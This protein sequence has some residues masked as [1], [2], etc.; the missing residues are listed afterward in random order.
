MSTNLQFIKSATISSGSSTL[1]ITNVFSAD[2]DVY[3]IV[4]YGIS[5]VGTLQTD[6]DLRFINSSDSV[7]GD[8]DYDYAHLIMRTDASFTEQRNT[9]E[10]EFYRFFGESVDQ[11]VETNAQVTYIYNPFSSSSYTFAIYQSMVA[12]AGLKI[13]MKGIGVLKQTTSMTGFQ[14]KDNTGSRPFA[15]GEFAVYGVK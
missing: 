8:N 11:G 14:V 4:S 10:D 7:V 2:Y 3:K 6:P 9:N 1:N 13:G 5:T 15:G 12:S